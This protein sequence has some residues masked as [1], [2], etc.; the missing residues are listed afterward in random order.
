MRRLW[1]W[2]TRKHRLGSRS[3]VQRAKL[4]APADSAPVLGQ[5][6]VDAGQ[7]LVQRLGRGLELRS[8]VEQ[9]CQ[10]RTRRGQGRTVLRHDRQVSHAAAFS[11]CLSSFETTAIAVGSTDC[12]MSTPT[13]H[14]SPVSVLASRR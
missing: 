13:H 14:R 7:L 2:I 6:R 1:Q 11:S 12:P 3:L 10:R 4:V 8:L 5:R 9:A